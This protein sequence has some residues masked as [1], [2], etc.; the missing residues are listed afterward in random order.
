MLRRQNKVCHHLFLGE[1]W[2][3]KWIHLYIYSL[4]YYTFINIVSQ[5]KL[6]KL[7]LTKSTFFLGTILWNIKKSIHLK[8]GCSPGC[9]ED[10]SKTP[11]VNYRSHQ[12]DIHHSTRHRKKP[13]KKIGEKLYNLEKIV[14]TLM[15]ISLAKWLL[16]N[17]C[18]W[19]NVYVYLDDFF[20]S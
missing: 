15:K 12:T 18:M 6:T 3:Y 13:S 1:F 5:T 4:M 11:G 10:I 20:F 17:I 14:F 16:M 2:W 7:K 8:Q 19:I 9:H